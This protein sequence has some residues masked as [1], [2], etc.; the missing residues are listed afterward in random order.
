MNQK[1]ESE[2]PS[3]QGPDTR[4]QYWEMGMDLQVNSTKHP[5]IRVPTIF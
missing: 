5:Y 1:Q 3:L 4:S 2:L